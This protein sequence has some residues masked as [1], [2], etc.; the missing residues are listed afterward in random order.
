MVEPRHGWLVTVPSVSPENS[1]V[2]ADGQAAHVC[3]G[4]AMDTEIIRDLFA[5]CIEASQRLDEDEAFRC[6]LQRAIEKLAPPQIGKQGQLQEWLDDFEEDEPGHRHVSHLYAVYPSNQITVRGTPALAHAAKCSLERR[7]AHGGGHTGW[8]AAWI[9]ALWARLAEPERAFAMLQQLLSHSTFDNLFDSHPPAIFQIDGNLGACAAIAELLLQSHAG[10]IELL[11]AL[12]TAWHTG[13][14]RGL[15]ARGGF[16][17]DIEWTRVTL[18]QAMIRSTLGGSCRV[19]AQ[20]AIRIWD[21]AGN[22]I[23]QPVADGVWQFETQA[24]RAYRIVTRA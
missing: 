20:V 16:E 15:R 8:S 18:T 11:P 7:L 10:E 3:A 23:G 9:I 4:P 19:R 6:E 1:F 13:C 2:T 12:P 14:V 21:E 17:V 24:D 22:E 5:H